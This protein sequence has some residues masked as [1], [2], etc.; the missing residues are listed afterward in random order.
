[1]SQTQLFFAGIFCLLALGA[2]IPIVAAVWRLMSS[3]VEFSQDDVFSTGSVP[4]AAQQKLGLATA[5]SLWLALVGSGVI[6]FYALKIFSVGRVVEEA[7]LIPPKH[8]V[9][10][11]P[12][13]AFSIYV[14]RLS[15]FFLLLIGSLSVGITIYSFAYLRQKA[16][17]AQIAAVYN[18][19]V[20]F[21][22][23]FV[24]ANN[25][26]FF[27]VLLECVTLTFGALV[28]HKQYEKP[29]APEHQQ[30]VK[31]YLIANHIGGVFV[32]TALLI[33]AVAQHP[34]TFDINLFR[35]MNKTTYHGTDS[36]IFLL[37]FIGFGIKAGIAPFHIWVAIA[38]PSS[39]TNTHA[40]SLGIMIKIALYGMIRVFFQ[41]LHPIPWWWGLVVL[42]VAALTAVIGV[43]NA[44]YGHTL[45]DSLADHSV[46]NIGIILAGIGL[47]LIFA[48]YPGNPA[49]Y[50]LTGL[51]L[52][53]G[54]YHLLNHTVFK[55]LLYLCTG[56]I[57]QLTGGVVELN[58][59]GGLIHRYRW[60]SVCFLVGSV[61]IAGFPP[62]NGF[63]SEWLTLQ[64]LIA[65]LNLLS[66]NVWLFGSIVLS[67]MLLAFAF[68]LTAFAFVK[69]VGEVFLG[70]PRDEAVVAASAKRDVPWRMRGVLI[71]LAVLCLL[72][73]IFPGLVISSLGMIAD[74]LGF[75]LAPG[76][77]SSSWEGVQIHIGKLYSAN[78]QASF[79]Y[80]L[81]GLV[82][83]V[84]LMA[85]RVRQSSRT[86]PVW[87]GGSTRYNPSIMQYTSSTFTSPI[88]DFLERTLAAML[89]APIMQIP[90][91]K[92]L[93]RL[94]AQ[95]PTAAQTGGT[96]AISPIKTWFIV[97]KGR[98]VREPFRQVYNRLINLLLYAARLTSSFVQNGDLSRYL[99]YIFLFFIVVFLVM[100]V[101]IK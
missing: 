62:F 26:F 41:F 22:V 49:I 88:R 93:I 24:V 100:I 67:T 10:G 90:I 64:T 25:V 15:A 69:I 95:L 39:P 98:R 21:G 9:D 18:L 40:M 45:K 96:A 94:P 89:F 29:D 17:R 48:S 37:A 52:L 8:F 19:F 75:P 81:L 87:I 60:T 13:I 1:M 2:L 57:D 76:N 30:A 92:Q 16:D 4:A 83:F 56:A 59:L 35:M 79:L 63:I 77:V 47:A 23:L 97:S 46:E 33:L 74:D 91:L 58:R 50:G 99:T 12:L 42:L 38:H 31:T 5:A 73:G 71:V 72:L 28:L 11:L 20:L 82:I 32:L 7:T 85:M 3:T 101:V 84:F 70:Q 36:L 78:L 55:G 51:A 53:A 43:R 80:V 44:L 34:A 14:D 86:R 68:A 65:G 27:I 61:A 6:T 54:L 66:Q